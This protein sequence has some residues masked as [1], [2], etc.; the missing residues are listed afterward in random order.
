[1]KTHEYIALAKAAIPSGLV[2]VTE[3]SGTVDFR[4]RD[5]GRT[6][7]VET[8]YDTCRAS[9]VPPA[10][11]GGG[12]GGD[13]IRTRIRA[14]LSAAGWRVSASAVTL[15]DQRPVMATDLR[16]DRRPAPA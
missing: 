10:G 13:T 7:L 8:Q 15:P 1:M 12:S 2:E 11:G 9:A 6:F 3:A 5:G 4:S 14:E 16:L